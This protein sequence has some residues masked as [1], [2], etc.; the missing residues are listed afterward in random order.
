MHSE[1]HQFDAGNGEHQRVH[2]VHLDRWEDLEI[3][4]PEPSERAL[5]C[6]GRIYRQ[7]LVPAAPWVFGSL[8]L[9]RLPE[10][11]EMP[12]SYDCGFCGTVADP[13]T[14]AAVGL[15]RG[16]RILGKRVFFRDKRTETFWKELKKRDCVRIVQGKLPITSVIPVG[17]EAG[18]LTE[19]EPDAA[20]KVNSSF[21]TMD[22]FDCA[23]AYDRIGR[24]FGL[25]VRDGIVEQPPLFSR[26]ALLVKND[27]SVSVGRPE[28]EDLKVRIGKK[29]FV[30]G[31]NCT[32]CSRPGYA[33][34]P[35]RKG[36]SLVILDR[37]VAAVRD[38]FVPVPGAG[39][40]I[41]TKDAADICPGDEVVYEGME[42]IRFGIQVGNSIVCD[43]IPTERFQSR[44]FNV[45]GINRIA[46]P[47]SLYPLDYRNSR[48]AR[49]AIG[50]DKG[51]KPMILWAEGA[52]KT[53][54]IPG[55][56]S[57][58]AT[59][60]DMARFCTELGM[61]NGVNLDGGGSAQLL[62]GNRRSLK[63][64]DRA[65]D[66]TEMERPVPLGLI[67]K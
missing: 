51:G 2:L 58:G 49:I 37:K 10:G 57:I 8:V 18:F 6:F 4:R 60:A 15:Q 43:G 22:P 52:A 61:V 16:I 25:F 28:L 14:A 1:I 33:W 63:I 11:M 45:R 21:F 38:G 35:P 55:Q 7:F 34:T 47:P 20:M 40:V 65:T 31:R 56:G 13:L 39:F 3:L 67:V 44:F 32:F 64:S 62:L 30:H 29:V 12:F 19:S 26:E 50:A 5:D 59:L 46:Y 36:K 27:G 9:F 23:T 48:A 24:P 42:H 54:H 53:G 66:G 41:C 17:P